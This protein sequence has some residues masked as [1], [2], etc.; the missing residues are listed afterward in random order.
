MF[1]FIHKEVGTLFNKMS[2]KSWKYVGILKIELCCHPG[3][4]VYVR[5]LHFHHVV[6]AVSSQ[7]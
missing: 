7:N 5:F 6:D 1:I 2:R 3:I 4:S